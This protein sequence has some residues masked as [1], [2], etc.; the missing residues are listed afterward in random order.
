M[1]INPKAFKI[2]MVLSLMLCLSTMFVY[3]QQSNRALP[4]DNLGYPVLISF[5][6]GVFGSGFYL[7]TSSALYLVTAKHVLFDPVTVQPC[8]TSSFRR[9]N[10]AL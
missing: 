1:N 4:D 6:G 2:S 8:F 5:D 3:A 9:R 10:V 7:D